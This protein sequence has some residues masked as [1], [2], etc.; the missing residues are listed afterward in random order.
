MFIGVFIRNFGLFAKV[1]LLR[2]TII[3]RFRS[4]YHLQLVEGMN[5]FDNMSK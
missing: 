1:I 4:L 5:F 2:I 3:Q